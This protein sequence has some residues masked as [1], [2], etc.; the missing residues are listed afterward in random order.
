[1]NGRAIMEPLMRGLVAIA[2]GSSL[3]IAC[4]GGDGGVSPGSPL[5]A[6]AVTD[7]CGALCSYSTECGTPDSDFCG[8]DCENVVGRIRGDVALDFQDCYLGTACEGLE[9]NDCESIITDADGRPAYDSFLASCEA[10]SQECFGGE[11]TCTGGEADLF[12]S[13][14]DATLQAGTACFDLPCEQVSGCLQD[15]FGDI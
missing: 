14:S 4:G 8:G 12:V 11:L 5:S 1:M 9:G 2:I 3:A 7:F 13:F 15:A 10:G 6:S